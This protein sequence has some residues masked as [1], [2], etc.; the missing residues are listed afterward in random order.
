MSNQQKGKGMN[1]KELLESFINDQKELPKIK[2]FA[3]LGN[4]EQFSG[5]LNYLIK[6]AEKEEWDQTDKYTSHK[7]STIFYYI[8]H[9]FDRCFDQGKI[10]IDDS[11]DNAFFNTGLMTSQGL[12]IF[13]HFTKSIFYDD[14]SRPGNY[15]YFKGFYKSNEKEFMQK[16]PVAPDI[17]TYFTDFNELYFDP[18]LEISMNFDHIYDDNKGR[19]PDELQQYPKDVAKSIIDGALEYTK[20]KIRRNNRIPVPQFYDG[21]IMFLIPVDVLSRKLVLALERI[22]N[23]YIANTILEMGMAYN[24]ARLLNKPE[25]DWLLL[26]DSNN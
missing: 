2:R 11:K 16:C 5:K 13:G 8:V 18:N 22:N 19:L 17:A 15:W 25:S 1:N 4:A 7:N 3:Y 24:C 26:K 20:K 6:I 23:K 14:D 12:E 9:T 10:V 21:S